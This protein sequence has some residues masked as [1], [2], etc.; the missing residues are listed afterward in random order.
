MI[1]CVYK[2]FNLFLSLNGK[3]DMVYRYNI[4]R[5]KNNLDTLGWYI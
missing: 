2:S 3:Y 4:V 5:Y 1:N